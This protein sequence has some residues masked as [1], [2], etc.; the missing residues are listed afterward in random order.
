MQHQDDVFVRSTEYER[1]FRLQAESENLLKNMAALRR[2]LWEMRANL[3]QLEKVLQ[4]SRDIKEEAG[5]LQAE[6]HSTAK[7]LRLQIMMT[8]DD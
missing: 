1:K 6:L 3:C 4:E 7:R 5:C 8:G 2:T